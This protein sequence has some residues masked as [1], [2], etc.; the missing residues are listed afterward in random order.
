ME[1]FLAIAIMI[2]S[3]TI[4]LIPIAVAMV[5][6]GLAGSPGAILFVVGQRK[7]QNWIKLTGLLI[8]ALGQSYVVGSYSVF[9]VSLLRDFSE[10]RPDM[11]TWPLWIATLFHSVAVPTYAMKE[12]TDQPTAQ[13]YTLGIVAILSLCVFCVI[14]FVPAVLR[15]IYGW[16][17]LYH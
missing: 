12:K 3:F 8:A 11:P 6:M 7:S 5:V 15:P 14:A 16:V 1:V 13:H 9:V 2:A 10:A 17:P 4:G